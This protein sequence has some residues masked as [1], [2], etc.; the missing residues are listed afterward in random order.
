MALLD[1]LI[2]QR[3]QRL[4]RAVVLRPDRSFSVNELVRIGGESKSAGIAIIDRFAKSRILTEERVGNQRRLQFNSEW[5][6]A[7]EL[8]DMFVKSF[9][10]AEPIT[11]V[12]TPFRDRI[13]LAFVFGSVVKGNDHAGSDIDLMVVGNVST[14]ELLEAL[15]PLK[16]KLMRPVNFNLYAPEEWALIQSDPVV[17]SIMSGPRITLYDQTNAAESS[18]PRSEGLPQRSA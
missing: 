13:Q 7:Q 2:P 9:G 4:L 16:E 10:V 5:P 6:L 18:E 1:A 17:A 8:R 11:E 12:L 15:H 3:E 14:M